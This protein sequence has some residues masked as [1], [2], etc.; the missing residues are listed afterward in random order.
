M[1]AA[2]VE[3]PT[4]E[5]DLEGHVTHV[6]E[7]V[8]PVLAPNVPAPQSVHAS[9][10]T[11]VLYLPVTHDVHEPAGPVLPV[12]Q[13]LLQSSTEELELVEMKP[14]GRDTQVDDV[15][16]P[17][18]CEY[19]SVSHAVHAT[20]PL[21]VLYLPE[22]H[23]VHEPAGSVLPAA[24]IHLQSPIPLLPLI[25]VVLAGHASHLFDDTCMSTAQFVHGESPLLRLTFP[26][27]HS[28]HSS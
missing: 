22:S 27:S 6:V 13:D 12:S 20:L 10:P 21:I 7:F 28:L 2:T 26:A 25:D 9:L 8:A 14:A 11:L 1:Q 16:V 19:V 23:S 24:H 3:L 18:A 15:L 17:T 4:G 5:L